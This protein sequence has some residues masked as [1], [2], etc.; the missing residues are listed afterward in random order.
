MAWGQVY[1]IMR[2]ERRVLDDIAANLYKEEGCANPG[3]FIA[4]WERLHSKKGWC[5]EQKVWVH[6]F[7]LLQKWEEKYGPKPRQLELK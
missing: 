7:M 5:P 2:I 1:I 4:W 3:E 6:H